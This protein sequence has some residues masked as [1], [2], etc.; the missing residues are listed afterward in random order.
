MIIQRN[1]KKYTN[2]VSHLSLILLTL[3]VVL[4]NSSLLQKVHAQESAPNTV[5][6]CISPPCC[7]PFV[8]EN[9][10]NYGCQSTLNTGIRGANGEAGE[11][12]LWAIQEAFIL[13]RE[14]LIKNVW[15]AHVLPAMMLSTQ[16]ITTVAMQQMQIIGSFFDAKHQ[17]E[18][19]RLLQ[20]LQAD[21]HKQYQPSVGM[22]RI[23]TSTRTLAI[24][25]RKSE[26]NQIA[27]A[28]RSTERILMTE[29]GIGTGSAR[30]ERRS[31]R[32]QFRQI[33]CNPLDMGGALEEICE[34]A[35]KSLINKDVNYTHTLED[36]E[37]L[38][39]D[40]TNDSLSANERDVLALQAN[41]YGPNLLPIIGDDYLI[42]DRGQV[43]YKG[44]NLYLGTRALAAK[45]SVAQNSYAA[46]IGLKSRGVDNAFGYMEEILLEMGIPAEDIEKM[47]KGNPSYNAMMEVLTKKLYQYP[48]FYANLYDKPV[49]VDRKNVSLQ[50]IALMQ[51]RDMYRAQLRSEANLAVWLETFLEDHQSYHTNK[52]N[53]FT[54]NTPVLTNLG[55]GG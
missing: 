8:E 29:R 3:M 33:Y 1:P 50:A 40:F 41:L 22:C 7:T 9:S 20:D 54:E 47:T 4:G 46:Q 51:K 10:E 43:L 6:E 37:T 55:L 39:I 28:A 18:T 16:Q 11:G 21:A 26:F 27:M 15:E 48:N 23:G 12:T 25:D 34:S 36:A 31:R 5:T 13:H 14:W 19:Q 53:G 49:N 45:R 44:S 35:D 38:D 2:H 17:L 24:A 52:S 30:D 32:E 42:N